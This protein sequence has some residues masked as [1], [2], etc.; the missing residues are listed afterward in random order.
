[1][2][3]RKTLETKR[4]IITL[5]RNREYHAAIKL[6]H[7]YFTAEKPAD[8]EFISS[9]FLELN[10]LNLFEAGY[11]L[12]ADTAPWHP[13][14]PE[15]ESL[16][17]NAGKLY[18]DSL[19]LQGNNLIFERE[20]KTSR[21]EESLKRSDSLS[22]EKMRIENEKIL[23]SITQKAQAVFEKA[24][25]IQP[26]NLVA[27]T[28]LQNCFQY[29]GEQE[30]LDEVENEISARNPLFRRFGDTRPTEQEEQEA[31]E[32]REAEK[33]EPQE[34][35]V[36]EANLNEIRQLLTQ[37]KYEDLVKRVDFIH[38][39][40]RTSVPM[41]LLKTKA[42]AELR[43]FKDADATLFEAE[44][45]NSHFEE[46]K[47][48]KSDLAELKYR[49]LTIAGN[50][51]LKK[52]VAM[53]PS[54]GMN[55]FRKARVSIQRALALNPESL[56]LL[57]QYYTALKYLGEEEEAFKT[58]AVIYNL[59]PRFVPTFDTATSSALCFI[60]SFA[61]AGQPGKVDEF[62]W[63]RREFLLSSHLGRYFNSIY[64]RT[65]PRLVSLAK[66]VP[67]A[68][69]FL[70]MLLMVPLVAIRILR[71]LYKYIGAE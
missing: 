49:L 13:D 31:R 50:T 58:K 34:V 10:R 37:K 9:F 24:R 21:L 57:D 51:Y 23:V 6:F 39:S 55:H 47:N 19:V 45:Q 14:D 36:E 61:F 30:K 41:L 15:H 59:N 56:D 17:E 4:K 60:A 71:F 27:L 28:G 66:P 11:R 25:E 46:V 1:M 8:V 68:G 29:L 67:L 22:R 12:L 63:F 64:V 18:V 32:A 2:T 33:F 53:G 35:D 52:G 26:D 3:E 38:L 48:V 54:L 43:R 65:S 7:K 16:R 42:L 69:P 40:H 70:R 44:R 20:E 62:R 5:T